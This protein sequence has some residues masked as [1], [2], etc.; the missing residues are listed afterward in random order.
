MSVIGC[1]VEVVGRRLV[2]V[3]LIKVVGLDW[4]GVVLNGAVTLAVVAVGIGGVSLVVI[5]ALALAVT[6]TLLL[7]VLNLARVRVPWTLLVVTL[8]VALMMIAEFPTIVSEGLGE[9]RCSV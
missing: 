3:G 4:I 8:V 1:L 9:N 6:L 7:L 5:L 2:V